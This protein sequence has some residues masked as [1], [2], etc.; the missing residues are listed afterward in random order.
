MS[1]IK[2]TAVA[3]ALALATAS[4]SFA[5]DTLYIVNSG[6]KGGS[7]N[8]QL[9]ALSAG[10]NTKYNIE[11]V[12]AKGCKKTVSILKKLSS[13]GASAISLYSSSSSGFKKE[14]TFM[15]PT[16]KNYL[17]AN[18]KA[19]IIFS[20]KDVKNNFLNNGNTIGIS[21]ELDKIINE[22]GQKNNIS[23]KTVRYKNAKSVTL[24]VLN[25]EVDF[26]ISNNSKRFWKNIDKL[27]GHFVLFDNSLEGIPSLKKLGVA[28]GP[29]LDVYIYFGTN[30]E[31]LISD[32]KN[33]YTSS[34]SDYAKWYSGQKGMKNNIMDSVE[35]R[36]SDVQAYLLP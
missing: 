23:F 27:N 33:V 22:I 7:Y 32:I 2:S 4:T 20:H 26:G 9:T 3:S 15:R 31:K 17:F 19:G 34:N 16:I 28:P 25:K 1:F 21:S 36:I 6:S 14:C 10:L 13:E 8:G 12:Q 24:G 35:S 11:Y 5:K 18:V 30:R 29:S